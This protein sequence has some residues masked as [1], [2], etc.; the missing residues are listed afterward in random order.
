MDEVPFIRKAELVI[1]PVK[2]PVSGRR[3]GE[4]ITED[5][6]IEELDPL[7]VICAKELDP[8]A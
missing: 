8:K 7:I 2:V 4:R 1:S 6:W 3:V 5:S